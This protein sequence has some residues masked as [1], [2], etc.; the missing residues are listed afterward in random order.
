[1]LHIE[2]ELAELFEREIEYHQILSVTKA[3]LVRKRDWSI[4][5]AMLTLDPT[6]DGFFSF[7]HILSF[8]RLNRF[9]ISDN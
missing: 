9:N 4:F 8:C 3:D 6:R 7:N 2:K 5:A 1:L